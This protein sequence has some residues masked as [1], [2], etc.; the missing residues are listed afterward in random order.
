MRHTVQVQRAARCAVQCAASGAAQATTYA[1]HTNTNNPSEYP[2]RMRGISMIPQA[3]PTDVI[4]AE[5]QRPGWPEIL[6]AA[7]AYILSYLI[8]PP[9]VS[10]LTDDE[11]VAS[12]LSL[13]ALSGIMGLLAFFAAFAIRVRP[14]S[15]FNVRAITTRWV[16]FS[17]GFGLLAFVLTRVV[18]AVFVAIAGSTDGD[19]QGDY[20]DAAN[21]GPLALTLQLLFIAVLTPIGEEFAFRGV[22][23]TALTRYGPWVSVIGSTVVFALAHGINLALIPALVVGAINGILLVR[24]K[25]VWPGVIVHAVNNG[26][27]TILVVLAG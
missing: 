5:R 23:S 14:W 1:N 10:A 16:F 17:L 4:G 24:T 9:I 11:S 22:I 25:S 18:A 19:P 6:A 21:A 20:H 7:G 27:A 15:A 3:T 2:T 8:G 12:G 26:V 13:A